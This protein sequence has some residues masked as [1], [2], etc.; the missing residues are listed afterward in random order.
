[1][2]GRC[3]IEQNSRIGWS[4]SR[5]GGQILSDRE[6]SASWSPKKSR[7][8]FRLL[9]KGRVAY[10]QEPIGKKFTDNSLFFAVPKTQIRKLWG[11]SDNNCVSSQK[12]TVNFT[13]PDFAA[14]PIK[15]IGT[16][17]S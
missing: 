10:R 17:S 9:E 8:L 7:L 14:V 6:V 16:R 13:V 5:P 2:E 4:S 1:M 12:F 3:Q 15:I 11:K